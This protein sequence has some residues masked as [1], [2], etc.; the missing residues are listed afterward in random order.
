MNMDCHVKLEHMKPWYFKLNPNG[1]VPTMLVHPNN[2]PVCESAHIVKYME[3]HFEG[4]VKL[5]PAD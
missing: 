5:L 2:T 3:E 1:Y 4:N